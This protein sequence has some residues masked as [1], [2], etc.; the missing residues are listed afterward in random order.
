MTTNS[1]SFLAFAAIA[2]LATPAP[3][4]SLAQIHRGHTRGS[5]PYI[6]ETGGLVNWDGSILIGNRY[7]VSH[8]QQGIY[9]ITYEPDAWTATPVMTCTPAGKHTAL[10][11]CNVQDFSLN[12]AV[13]RMY[14]VS[15][16]NPVNNAFAF[17]A[18]LTH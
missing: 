7:S 2:L 1:I 14:R 5:P 15:N 6:T 17:T 9:T 18:V 13:V 10:A 4:Q 8:T 12:S 11:V 16:G 3:A